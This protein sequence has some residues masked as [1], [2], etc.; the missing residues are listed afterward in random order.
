MALWVAQ[1]S[2][3][4]TMLGISGTGSDAELTLLLDGIQSRFDRHCNR[5]LAITA[6]DT[7]EYADG[8]QGVVGLKRFPIVSITAIK[9]ASDRDFASAD[10]LTE[11]DDFVQDP[12]SGLVFRVGTW[13]AGV[14]T[15]QIVYR[16][17]YAAAGATL[18][19]GETEM[20]DAIQRAALMQ[21]RYEWQNR[22]Q[23]G[24]QQ[25]AANGASVTG[26]R[27]E[28]LPEVRQILDGYR[29]ITV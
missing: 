19:T 26:A 28:L 6:S 21:A 14:R 18:G 2:E 5:T 9:E 25:V 7:T 8:G 17:G 1:L 23:L 16:G 22:L 3:L 4:K 20:P 29:R 13:L 10:A 15:V 24:S 11:D 12:D 27:A